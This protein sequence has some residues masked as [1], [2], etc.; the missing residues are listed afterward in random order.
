MQFTTNDD[1]NEELIWSLIL[2]TLTSNLSNEASSST[3]SFFRTEDGIECSVR[4]RNGDLIA[5][6]Y[7]ESDRMGKRRW[8]IEIK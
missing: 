1:A 4:K 7:S 5:N 8:T 6:C 3:S 2:D